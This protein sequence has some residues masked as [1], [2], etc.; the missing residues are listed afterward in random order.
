MP[1]LLIL[2]HLF[3]NKDCKY[4]SKP[5]LVR[6][7][8]SKKIIAISFVTSLIMVIGTVILSAEESTPLQLPESNNETGRRNIL[9]KLIEANKK[10]EKAVVTAYKAIENGVVTGYKTIENGVVNG[11]KKIETWF[12]EPFLAPNSQ[13]SSHTENLSD[14]YLSGETS[15]FESINEEIELD[16]NEGHTA[17]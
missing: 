3:A 6:Y 4:K 2:V 11:Y 10:M 13:E 5:I 17:Q 14:E 8:K 7:M 12:T 15:T 16:D 9:N 1:F